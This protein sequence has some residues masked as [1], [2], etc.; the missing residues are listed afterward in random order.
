MIELKMLTTSVEVGTFLVLDVVYVHSD[1]QTD[2]LARQ[3]RKCLMQFVESENNIVKLRASQ[4]SH[5][6]ECR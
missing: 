5:A 2:G 1:L 6:Q 4:C 3:M